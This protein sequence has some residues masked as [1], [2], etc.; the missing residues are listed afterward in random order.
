MGRSV[1]VKTPVQFKI[2]NKINGFVH[3]FYGTALAL[4]HH[5]SDYNSQERDLFFCFEIV[6][7]LNMKFAALVK[8][9]LEFYSMKY[10][11]FT[12]RR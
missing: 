1:P 10:H 3:D 8:I 11:I 7:K 12:M 4:K 5:A 9:C 2:V 6:V